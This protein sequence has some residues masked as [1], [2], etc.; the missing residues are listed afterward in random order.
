MTKSAIPSRRDIPAADKWDMSSLYTSIEDWNG[1]LK[2]LEEAVEK[3]ARYRGKLDS[4]D[5]LF[6][7]LEEYKNCEMTAEKLGNYASLLKSGDES[8]SANLDIFGRFMIVMVKAQTESSFFVPELQTIPE[9]EL[10]S[11]IAEP[12]YAEY[13]VYIEKLLRMRPYILSEREERLFA[14]QGEAEETAHNAFSALTNADFDF[15]MVETPDGPRPLSQT[16][17]SVFMESPD[18]NVRREAYSRFYGIFDSHKNTIAAL[19]SGSVHYDVFHARA[20]GYASSRERALFPDR[21]SPSVY[22]NLVGTI[23]ANLGPLHRYYSLRK[24][25][26]KLDELRHYDVYVPLVK[27]VRTDI[28]YA[29]AVEILRKALSPLGKEYTDTLCGG[30]TGGWVDKYENRGKRS[31]AFSS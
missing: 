25:V 14:L 26:L 1:D 16:T 7:C 31:G 9:N 11:W 18:R 24:R 21:V 4:S 13:R 6:R 15:G 28:P 30:L 27:D 3:L 12:R 29:E 19:Y 22:D 20:R 2:R 8:D 10:R 23:R 17:F 5:S